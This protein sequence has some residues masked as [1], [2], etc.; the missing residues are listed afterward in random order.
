VNGPASF[1]LQGLTQTRSLRV[2]LKSLLPLTRFIPQLKV[3]APLQGAGEFVGL[4][5]GVARDR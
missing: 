5:P 2:F 4:D 1:S 3:L